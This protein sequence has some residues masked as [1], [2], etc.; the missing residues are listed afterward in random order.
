MNE[1]T[2]TSSGMDDALVAALMEVERHVGSA[3]WGQPARLFAL[4]PTAE[5]I[6]AEPHLAEHLGVSAAT[7]PQP[8][9]LTPVEQDPWPGA[10]DDRPWEALSRISFPATVHGCVLS[11]ERAFLSSTHAAELSDD[12]ATAAEQVA[13][14]PRAQEIRAVVGVT[15]TGGRHGVARL[16][17]H[18][19]D[20]LGAA[21]L[22][23]G[24]PDLLAATLEDDA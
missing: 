15:R 7:E 18:P 5:L 16:K 10:R 11:L 3:G 9:A 12:P 13:N 4:V 6:A 22:V 21:E 2:H 17:S 24:L 14:D 23:P 1:D 8:G 19:D 20:L